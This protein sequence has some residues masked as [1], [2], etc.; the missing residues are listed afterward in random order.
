MGHISTAIEQS[1]GHRLP[2]CPWRV[3]DESLVADVLDAHPAL[4]SGNLHT[5]L[6]PHPPVRLLD[7]LSLY[8][9][10]LTKLLADERRKSE[11]RS[12]TETRQAHALASMKVARRG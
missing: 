7:A 5:F 6:G 1:T 4:K 8:D 11:E 12:Q 10:T 2:G 3:F 9:R